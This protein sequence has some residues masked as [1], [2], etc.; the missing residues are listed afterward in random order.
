[1]S[2]IFIYEQKAKTFKSII[3]SE[4]NNFSVLQSFVVAIEVP[5]KKNNNCCDPVHAVIIILLL[6]SLQSTELIF[7]TPRHITAADCEIVKCYKFTGWSTEIRVY[8]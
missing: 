7:N 6:L 5:D 2:F 1:M 8:C 4:I 3:Q